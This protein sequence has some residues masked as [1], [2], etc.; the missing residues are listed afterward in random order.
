MASEQRA[1]SE[2]ADRELMP[3]PKVTRVP[4]APRWKVIN[5]D[6]VEM[7]PHT[8][9]IFRYLFGEEMDKSGQKQEK[10]VFNEFVF[11]LHI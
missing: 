1:S 6:Q 3:P 7:L 9:D 2:K 11:A 4:K 5:G 8:I 10:V